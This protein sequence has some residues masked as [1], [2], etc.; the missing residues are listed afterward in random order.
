MSQSRSG[1]TS[2]F[3]RADAPKHRAVRDLGKAQPGL[4]RS[5]RTGA[6]GGAAADL[7]DAPSGLAVD[8]QEGAFIEDLEPAAAVLG[9]VRAAIEADD[10]AAAQA[11]GKAQQQ[12]GAVAKTAQV[13]GQGGEH[14]QKVFGKKRLFLHRRAAVAAADAGHDLQNVA[15]GAIERR[16]L[17]AVVPAQ[18]REAP[19][20]G[21]GRDRRRR[22]PAPAFFAGGAGGEV[23][24][25]GF[26]VRR[27]GLEAAAPAPGQKMPPVGGIGPARVVGTG[28][29][30]VGAGLVG[31]PG[32]RRDDGRRR[33]K[34]RQARGGG[35]FV[36]RRPGPLQLVPAAGAADVRS[37]T[38]L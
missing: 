8:V 10:L 16:A 9:F 13:E 31:K 32:K 27:V 22:K 19:L 25:D 33:A 14:R 24:A 2:A 37:D 20:E 5:D 1:P 29:S 6:L 4:K 7:D 26:G 36:S 34:R 12:D 28:V 35:F 15:V 38:G 23:E 17:L 18:R 21:G 3:F 11:A 30:G